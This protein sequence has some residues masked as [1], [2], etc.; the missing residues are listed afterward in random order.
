MPGFLSATALFSRTAVAPADGVPDGPA[1]TPPPD[2]IANGVTRTV[3]GSELNPPLVTVTEASTTAEHNHYKNNIGSIGPTIRT[4]YY[5]RAGTRRYVVLSPC[6]TTHWVAVV[7]DTQTWTFTGSEGRNGAGACIHSI[8]VTDL[9]GGDKLVEIICT[10][11][12]A[13]SG[14]WTAIHGAPAASGGE[15]WSYSY[16][17]NGSTILIRRID[18]DTV[19][20]NP[21]LGAGTTT[22]AATTGTLLT[23]ATQ[24][25][26]AG[27]ACVVRYICRTTVT[28][29]YT[30]PTATFQGRPV[31]FPTNS[32][33]TGGGAVDRN[34]VGIGF[35]C[36]LTP[37]V[38]GSFLLSSNRSMGQM[39]ARVDDVA[40]LSD[41]KI[42]TAN[43]STYGS[44][45]KNNHSVAAVVAAANSLMLGVV[46]GTSGSIDPLTQAGDWSEQSEDVTGTAATDVAATFMTKTGGA[47]AST[48]TAAATGATTTGNWGAAILEVKL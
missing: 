45:A 4:R 48:Q 13:A 6:T 14:E 1:A 23:G 29:T 42:G 39:V 18:V 16:L 25:T 10:L 37:G 30:T 26:P 33:A 8:S 41:F 20:V 40:N 38:A 31:T 17:G 11:G 2:W 12:S 28:Q 3:G 27:R 32:Q 7:L 46:G 9:G 15:A 5:I 47:A 24:H 22:K 35:V 36:D 34:L 43:S 19:T 44:T 21:V